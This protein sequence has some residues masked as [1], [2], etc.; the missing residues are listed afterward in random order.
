M[1]IRKVKSKT[2]D[3]LTDGLS[4]NIVPKAVQHTPGPW[5]WKNGYLVGND[6]TIIAEKNDDGS[7]DAHLIADAPDL[8]AALKT[9][10]ALIDFQHGDCG[11]AEC[12]ICEAERIADAT[13]AKTEGGK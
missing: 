12:R 8:L 6:G 7:A 4:I 13:I 10:S 2:H 1:K 5:K 3:I 11:Q 9:I